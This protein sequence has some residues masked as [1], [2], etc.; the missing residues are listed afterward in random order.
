MLLPKNSC[1]QETVAVFKRTIYGD[2]THVMGIRWEKR[3][4]HV[5]V[6]GYG[7]VQKEKRGDKSKDRG[8]REHE[9]HTTVPHNGT[10]NKT[11]KGSLFFLLSL[12]P[13]CAASR[14]I[15]PHTD[16]DS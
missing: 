16:E 10:Q 1:N 12:H 8:Q 4:E 3:G 5:E 15:S 11:T 14:I 7:E 2:I 6:I 13:S 9:H